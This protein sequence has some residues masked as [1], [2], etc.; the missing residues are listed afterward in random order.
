[1][2]RN[3]P[4][5]LRLCAVFLL[6]T[7]LPMGVFSYVSMKNDVA[8]IK[9]DQQ[10]F[11]EE[12]A[13]S[14]AMRLQ[15]VLDQYRILTQ[16]MAADN[17]VVNYAYALGSTMSNDV[18]QQAAHDLQKLHQSIADIRQASIVSKQ[19]VVVQSS[20]KHLQGDSYAELGVFQQALT[21]RMAT[22]Y[23]AANKS[24]SHLSSERIYIAAPIVSSQQQVLAVMLL[25]VD[26]KALTRVV[27]QDAEHHPDY[28]ISLLHASEQP[29]YRLAPADFENHHFPKGYVSAQARINNSTWQVQ[30]ARP[31]EHV[32]GPIQ[33][34]L[35][36]NGL[37]LL[38]C[39]GSS[40]LATWLVSRRLSHPIQ[41]LMHKSRELKNGDYEVS[42]W[43]HDLSKLAQRHDDMGQFI[44]VYQAMI[45][46]I[47]QREQTLEALVEV[48]TT[49]LAHKNDLLALS[50][51]RLSQE[52]KLADN[53]QQA[54]LPQHFPKSARFHVYAKM[55]PAKEM[56]GDFYDCFMLDNGNYALLVADVAGKGVSAAF[57]MAISSTIIKHAANRYAEPH[58]ALAYAND[59]LC[60][61]NPM[62]LFVTVFYAVLNPETLMLHYANAGH[63]SPLLRDANGNISVLPSQ[64]QLPL[65]AWEGVN[66][67][68][69]SQ[70]LQANQTLVFY[71]DGVT[72]ALSETDEEYGEERLKQWLQ[73]AGKLHNAQD[74]F[75]DLREEMRTFVGT[76]EPHDD[77]T[78]LIIKTHQASTT[79]HQQSWQLLPTF[80]EIDATNEGINTFLNSV[81]PQQAELIFNVN[82]CLEEVLTNLIR[83]GEQPLDVPIVI[84]IFIDEHQITAHIHDQGHAYHPFL[85]MAAVDTQTDVL[86]RDLGGL[87][88]HLVSSLMDEYDY[89]SDLNGNT[90]T[91]MAYLNPK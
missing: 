7:L 49:E 70:P 46:E 36:N 62:N 76:A 10:H 43:D 64:N 50:H 69:L 33:Q 31:Y 26:A 25:E 47:R 13:L 11:I 55:R 88:L 74:V 53:M 48:R 5:A 80:A 54:I 57:F 1:M 29:L 73:Q 87:G 75:I 4:I 44:S 9:A 86:E 8:Q 45:A 59:L 52:L 61:R 91:L 24:S 21:G 63:H 34:L 6:T 12:H 85:N 56:G 32:L 77:M 15:S 65:G 40:I 72:E 90:T 84:N 42:Q 78:V 20:R 38:F 18:I 89:Q 82:V 41:A 79:Q 2:L 67:T 51:A 27:K 66:Y 14:L 19:G 37:I 28:V 83:H 39:L 71:S 3:L 22:D 60:Q 30:I 35:L 23:V 58:L 68:P 81:L 16:T 17:D